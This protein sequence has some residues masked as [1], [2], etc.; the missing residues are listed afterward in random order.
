MKRQASAAL[1]ASLVLVATGCNPFFP[2]TDYGALPNVDLTFTGTVSGSA[3]IRDGECGTGEF[4]SFGFGA[5]LP[6][7]G[8]F[9][10]VENPQGVLAL[11]LD[12]GGST[13]SAAGISDA[14]SS[15][16]QRRTITLDADLVGEAGTAHVRGSISCPS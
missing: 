2:G 8:L 12:A 11:T 7:L 15:K 14:F 13:F 3:K 10:A 4:D 6:G 1:L 16:D 5:D 9:T